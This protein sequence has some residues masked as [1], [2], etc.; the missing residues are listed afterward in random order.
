MTNTEIKKALYK[1][2]PEALLSHIRGGIAH[3]ITVI[4]E[5]DDIATVYFE[6]PVVDMGDAD[7][8]PTM[9]AKLLARY[10]KIYEQ[11]DEQLES[12]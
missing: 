9:D 7:F 11:E 1:Q 6:V 4:K 5:D 2:K 10:I 8:F 3:Y 12:N